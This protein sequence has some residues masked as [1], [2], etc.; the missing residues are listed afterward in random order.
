MKQ[1]NVGLIGFGTVGKG[2]VKVLFNNISVIK[3]RVGTDIKIK[4]IADLDITTSRGVE[5]SREVLTTDAKEVI[6]DP[7]IDIVVELIGGYKPAKEFILN[8]LEKK[9]HVVTANKALLASEGYEIFKCAEKN[10]MTV[11]FEASVGG[12]I[13]IIKA[14]K[15]GLVANHIHSIYGIINGTSNYILTRMTDE[16]KEFKEVLKKAQE[17]GY[18]EADPSF[19]I[20]GIDSSHKIAILAALAYGSRINLKDVYT[21]GI[22][23]VSPLDIKYALELGYKIKLLAIAKEVDGEIDVRVHPTMIPMSN[24]LSS[25]G[26]VFNAI[27]LTG[28]AIGEAIFYG[29]GAGEFPTASAVV[30]DIVEISRDILTGAKNRVP[31]LSFQ[32]NRVRDKKI[33]KISKVVSR[34]YFRFSVIDK[35]GVLSKISGILGENNISIASVLQQERKE[36][37]E[38]AVVIMTHGA[39]EED[40]EKALSRI[41]QL[42][43]VLKDT[44][45]IRVEE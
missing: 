36:G 19:D 45:L 32:P 5:V 28:D 24:P 33:R 27:Y 42:P 31:S 7:E 8:A 35:P 18:A 21:E 40:V 3:D 4:K 43:V 2:V 25:V 6:N 44:V 26:G 13:P 10:Q 30:A 20:E 14:I 12:G 1:I 16:G 29:R 11:G 34:F 17:K 39:L 15:E 9:K 41:N 37:E 38:V 23:K 22:T